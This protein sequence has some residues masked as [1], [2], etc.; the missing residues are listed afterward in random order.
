MGLR[1]GASRHAFSLVWACL[2]RVALPVF[3]IRAYVRRPLTA[4][5]AHQVR[6]SLFP[7]GEWPRRVRSVWRFHVCL[8]VVNE[9]CLVA[10]LSGHE[11]N[12]CSTFFFS[13]S[14]SSSFFTYSAKCL[15][16]F[17]PGMHFRA[18][19]CACFEGRVDGAAVWCH[20]L[21]RFFFFWFWG[22]GG[23]LFM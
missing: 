3:A 12:P 20:T 9:I 1:A 19:L 18:L 23:L 4:R 16:R 7:L 17:D 8:A 21:C 13:S 11:R 14:S 5:A 2:A 15:A 10:S 6:F 22:G